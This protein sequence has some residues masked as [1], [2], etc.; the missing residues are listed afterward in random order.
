LVRSGGRRFFPQSFARERPAGTFRIMVIGDSVAR[1]RSVEASYAG[2]LAA[3]LNRAGAKA[4]SFNLSLPG[5]GA[6][7]KMIVLEQALKYQPSLIILHLNNSNE[8]EDERE[9]KRAEEFKGWHPRNWL[10]KSLV[11]RRL[12]EMKTEKLYWEW[13]PQEIRAQQG[14]SDADAEIRASLNTEKL[15]AWDQRVRRFTAQS[16]DLA[17]AQKV[18]VLLVSQANSVRQP[19]QPPRLEDNGLDALAASM[20]T[21]GVPAFSMR[22]AFGAVD[23]DKYFSDGSHLHREGHE[24]IARALA[25]LIRA[26]GLLK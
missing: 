10:M 17:R 14:A 9:F 8:Y 5:Y 13:L 11:I 1:G 26:Q 3:E 2:L 6:H 4:E 15:K 18:P 7:R 12:H 21:N 20:A 16:L 19:G 24:L 23:F 22:Q 25:D